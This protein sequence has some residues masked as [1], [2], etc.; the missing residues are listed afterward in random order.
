MLC[1][2]QNDD[3]VLIL[4]GNIGRIL[5]VLFL[6]IDE[7]QHLNGKQRSHGYHGYNTEGISHHVA[8]ECFTCAHGKRQQECGRHRTGRNA[9]RVKCNAGENFRHAE[10]QS[11]C[12]KIA[13]HQYII[14]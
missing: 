14:D 9:A 2:L 3:A 8:A 10:S 1:S 13:R 6:F 7:T 12:S 11:Q 4:C 5:A